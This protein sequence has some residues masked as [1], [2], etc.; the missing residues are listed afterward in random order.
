MLYLPA[1]FIVLCLEGILVL[2]GLLIEHLDMDG[3]TLILKFLLLEEEVDEGR[4]DGY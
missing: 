2:D 4:T 3:R 1:Q